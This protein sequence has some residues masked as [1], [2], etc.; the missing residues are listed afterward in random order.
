MSKLIRRTVRKGGGAALIVALQMITLTLLSLIGPFASGPQQSA[1]KAPA[2]SQVNVAQD[3]P[4]TDQ[5]QTETAQPIT[6]K[7]LTAADNSE[8][9]NDATLTTSQDD[10]PPFSYVY[11]HGSGFQP[12]ETVDMLVVETDPIQQSFDPW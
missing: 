4:Q 10:Y 2:D 8:L 1:N 11:F 5:A 9:P 3:Q 6:A 12:G 7:D